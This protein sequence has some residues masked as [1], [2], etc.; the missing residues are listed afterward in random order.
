MKKIIVGMGIVGV[1]LISLASA[2][3][4]GFLSN[5]VTGTIVVEGPVFYLDRTEIMGDG[6]FSLKLNDNDV[7]GDYFWLTAG[8]TD[9]REFFSESLG[10][11]GFYPLNFNI[12]LDA[13]MVDLN[14]SLNESGAIHMIVFLSR[15]SGSTRD[16]VLC[17][18]I[19][20]GVDERDDFS[21][22]CDVEDILLDINPTD[23]IKLLLN[24]GSPSDSK[25]KVYLGESRMQMVAK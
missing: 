6:S 11:D 19:Y 7:D 17:D 1:L 9:S 21:I 25:I 16:Q 5:T 14:E 24:D 8:D 18:T 2:G 20:L 15:E 23:R 4:V 3:L 22:M 13:E 10:V 12:I